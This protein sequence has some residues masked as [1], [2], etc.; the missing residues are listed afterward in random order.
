MRQGAPHC[1]PRAIRPIPAA[2]SCMPSSSA[3]RSPASVHQRDRARPGIGVAPDSFAQR[4]AAR[5]ACPPSTV[6]PATSPRWWRAGSPTTFANFEARP[7][8]VCFDIWHAPGRDFRG[9]ALA[10][11][12]ERGLNPGFFARTVHHVDTFRRCTPCGPANCAS[13][14][15]ADRRLVVSHLWRHWASAASSGTTRTQLRNGVDRRRFFAG[16]GCDRRRV[17]ARD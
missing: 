7:E 15:A 13:I 11:L 3:T 1:H 9:N 6:G 8:Q 17:A 10:T 2:G 12:K 16:T 4:S 14:T 5:R